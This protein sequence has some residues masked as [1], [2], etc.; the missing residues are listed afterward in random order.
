MIFPWLG[1]MSPREGCCVARE[2]PV[3]EGCDCR[4][5]RLLRV[6]RVLRVERFELFERFE[7]LE[8]FE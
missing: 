5:V 1:V 7:R 6:V 8:V 4:L 2:L 3:R